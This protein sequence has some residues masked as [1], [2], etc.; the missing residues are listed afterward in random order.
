MN[1]FLLLMAS[2]GITSIL[3]ITF[4]A[5]KAHERIEIIEKVRS[6]KP[7]SLRG[8]NCEIRCERAEVPH[9]DE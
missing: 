6:G 5:G 7:F 3:F 4:C 8:Y 1:L 2:V 9:H